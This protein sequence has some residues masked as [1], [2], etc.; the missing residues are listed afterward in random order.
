MATQNA[1]TPKTMNQVVTSRNSRASSA[2]VPGSSG[3]VEISCV[4][5]DPGTYAEV[6]L[7]ARDVTTWFIVFGVFAFWVAIP[8][9]REL[10]AYLGE[11]A[12]GA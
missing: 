9:A 8:A 10:R 5:E 1:K 2:Y 12:G 11:D 4:P 7:L 3:G 6:A